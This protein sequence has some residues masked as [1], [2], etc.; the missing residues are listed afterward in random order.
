MLCEKNRN[1]QKYS[2]CQTYIKTKWKIPPA[3]SELAACVMQIFAV[4]LNFGI[5]ATVV[6]SYNLLDN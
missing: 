5:T 3:G 6:Q 1:Y 2:A 4:L